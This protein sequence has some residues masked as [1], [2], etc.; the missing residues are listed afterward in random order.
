[1]NQLKGMR[2]KSLKAAYLVPCKCTKEGIRRE[3]EEFYFRL[4]KGNAEREY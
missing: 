1:M 2:E 4:L 3:E